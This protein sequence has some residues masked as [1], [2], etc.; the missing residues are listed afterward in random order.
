MVVRNI[1]KTNYKLTDKKY[2]F[3]SFRMV[4]EGIISLVCVSVSLVL[5]GNSVNATVS[6]QSYQGWET[7]TGYL[8]Q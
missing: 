4:A 6:I 3:Y 5:F 7:V 8:F 2:F 1:C